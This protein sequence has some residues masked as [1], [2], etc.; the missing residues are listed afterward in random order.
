MSCRIVQPFGG[1]KA[2]EA[3]LLSEHATVA[4]AFAEIDRLSAQMVRTGAPSN[5]IEV[6]VVDE[7]RPDC[8]TDGELIHGPSI[9][10][11]GMVT[12]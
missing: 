12:K 9:A 2:R 10:K 6:I 5:A 7:G 8:S 3:T 1:D 11:K 4:E